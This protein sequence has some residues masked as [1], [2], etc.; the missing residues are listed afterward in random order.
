MPTFDF[1]FSVILERL[2]V[3]SIS[4][5]T[6]DLSASCVEWDVKVSKSV[7]TSAHAVIMVSVYDAGW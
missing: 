6:D 4:E 7:S 3:K 2:A 5:M 1:V